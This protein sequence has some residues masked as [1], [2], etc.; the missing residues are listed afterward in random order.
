LA[1]LW[2]RSMDA[3]VAAAHFSRAPAKGIA[4]ERYRQIV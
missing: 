2:R 3:L 4:G 1:G